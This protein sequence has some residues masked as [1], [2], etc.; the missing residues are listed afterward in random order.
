MNEPTVFVIQS[1]VTDDSGHLRIVWRLLVTGEWWVDWEAAASM[2]QYG[3]DDANPMKRAFGRMARLL[4]AGR[5]VLDEVSFQQSE[6][7]GRDAAMLHQKMMM[8][9]Q[10]AAAKAMEPSGQDQPSPQAAPKTVH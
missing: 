7:T 3:P 5:S 8:D 1:S 9:A 2:A 4:L 6:Q 10:Q